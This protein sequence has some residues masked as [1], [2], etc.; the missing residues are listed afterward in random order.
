M[1]PVNS[2]TVSKLKNGTCPYCGKEFS[3]IDEKYK[4]TEEHV[5]GRRFIPVGTLHQQWNLILD[6]HMKCNSEKSKL[7]DD[8]SAIT[9][10]KDLRGRHHSPNE[11]LANDNKRKSSKSIS[12][13]TGKPVKDSYE[14]F[15]I[16]GRV[17]SSA[18]VNIKIV[19]PPQID[20][21]RIQQLALYHARA[22][23]YMIT[24]EE[25][26]KRGGFW[27]GPFMPI[28]SAFRADWGN[29]VMLEFMNLTK[30]W[31]MHFLCC[32]AENHFKASIRKH[33][34]RQLWSYATEWN[35]NLRFIAAFGETESLD[36]LGEQLPE[37]E[38]SHID[39]RWRVRAELS[40]PE[41][42]DTMFD[43]IDTGIK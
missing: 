8:I 1:R 38:Y 23:F 6:T 33:P 18:S 20:V 21:E 3:E 2:K 26:T 28:E 24:F 10:L 25:K 22:F 16:N 12:Q 13:V 19:A 42:N 17:G 27:L 40:L 31:D 36:W 35:R 7:E 32:S 41:E 15:E 9:M 43:D 11:K 5:I 30:S 29:L 4:A 39:G 37:H 34:Q 14:K